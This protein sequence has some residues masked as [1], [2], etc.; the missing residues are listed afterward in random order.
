M[1]ALLGTQCFESPPEREAAKYIEE[2][3]RHYD[4]RGSGAW[5]FENFCKFAE[6][7]LQVT[8]HKKLRKYW[9]DI[10]CYLDGNRAGSGSQLNVAYSKISLF[11]FCTFVLAQQDPSYPQKLKERFDR[12]KKRESIPEDFPNLFETDRTGSAIE[13]S[14]NSDSKILSAFSALSLDSP[15]PNDNVRSLG[16]QSAA[17]SKIEAKSSDPILERLPS[18]QPQIHRI[19]TVEVKSHKRGNS[20]LTDE[21]LSV[22]K[23]HMHRDSL[24][25][26]EVLDGKEPKSRLSKVHESSS[27]QNNS[28]SADNSSNEVGS[29]ASILRSGTGENLPTSP[30]KF[31][32]KVNKKEIYSKLESN[33][34]LES[35]KGDIKGVSNGHSRTLTRERPNSTVLH[36]RELTTDL[37]D[38]AKM[39]ERSK[40]S[41]PQ[42]SRGTIGYP[43]KVKKLTRKFGLGSTTRYFCIIGK[44]IF[45]TKREDDAKNIELLMNMK[46]ETRKK[47]LKK[48]SSK[49]P[50]K[51]YDAK[52]GICWIPSSRIDHIERDGA[53]F[54]ILTSIADDEVPILADQESNLKKSSSQFKTYTFRPYGISVAALMG[55][56][57]FAWVEGK[58]VS[59]LHLF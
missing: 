1:G 33:V 16:P 21:Q 59:N 3:F 2:L 51:F 14:T 45:Y 7:L 58:S 4:R 42:L 46:V 24:A 49:V 29:D 17:E 5:E 43:I 27:E 25:L 47:M 56:L 50:L 18:A 26:N 10:V 31:G 15:E 23:H 32:P 36:K 35:E 9:F 40:S 48:S 11:E 13:T 54:S 39:P 28:N 55:D 34:K 6:D 19:T 37:T 8:D 30:K 22:H 38:E 20:S 52:N 41:L 53:N 44:D 12:L 57:H